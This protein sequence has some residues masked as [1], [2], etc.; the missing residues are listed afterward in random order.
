M[1]RNK[2]A[3]RA[4]RELVGHTQA[5]LAKALGV[6]ERSVRRWESPSAPQV[7]PEDAWE[8]LEEA[9]EAQRQVVDFGLDKADE[10]PEAQE[11]S[12]VYWSSQSQYDEARGDGGDWRMANATARSLAS[13]LLAE[14]R[15]V[16]WRDGALEHEWSRDGAEGGSETLS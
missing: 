3:F 11:V 2:A 8:V 7:P 16:T 10:W 4:M 5:T 6:E 14:G 15:R 12:L 13:V 1:H 9:L